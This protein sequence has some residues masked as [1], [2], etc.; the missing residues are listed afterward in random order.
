MPVS[1]TTIE[2]FW[3]S[4]PRAQVKISEAYLKLADAVPKGTLIQQQ[5]FSAILN[6]LITGSVQNNFADKNASYISLIVI[7]IA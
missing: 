2:L 6:T 7:L 5:F 1:V 4:L 3:H